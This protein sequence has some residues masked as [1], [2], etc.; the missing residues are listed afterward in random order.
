MTLLP[1]CRVDPV[2]FSCILS[3]V[4]PLCRLREAA[5]H[6]C[7]R[8]GVSCTM[9]ILCPCCLSFLV[10]FS[11]LWVAHTFS[12][13][14]SSPQHSP[15]APAH[16]KTWQRTRL[17]RRSAWA[18]P[19][20]RTTRCRAAPPTMCAL[21]SGCTSPFSRSARSA[22]DPCARGPPLLAVCSC[23]YG[24]GGV[25]VSFRCPPLS[26][27]VGFSR[28]RVVGLRAFLARPQTERPLLLTVAPL[29]PS[30]APPLP[31][32]SRCSEGKA[33]ARRRAARSHPL[34]AGRVW[35]A[36]KGEPTARAHPRHARPASRSRA[37]GVDGRVAQT[38]GAVAG[39]ERGLSGDAAVG[40]GGGMTAAA[41]CPRRRPVS[42][43]RAG[44]W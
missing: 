40:G 33:H 39:G 32:L 19:S 20:T 18:K 36:A 15:P 25:A 4:W 35:A 41:G 5:T 27:C 31:S 21:A 2:P 44:G 9:L 3:A 34:G 28:L 12:V 14:V 7:C 1:P 23:V 16:C 24:L 22:A 26:F 38:A 17:S 8:M 43:R 10:V 30:M 37:R 42:C 29:R 13:G 6:C 11:V